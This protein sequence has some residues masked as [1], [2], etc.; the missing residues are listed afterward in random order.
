M[1]GETCVNVA[2]NRTCSAP[3]SRVS[4]W[5]SEVVDCGASKPARRVRVGGGELG[6]VHVRPEHDVDDP[7]DGTAAVER[8]GRD[9][10]D[11]HPLDQVDGD[12]VHIR[13]G[14]TRARQV[15]GQRGHNLRQAPP[16][17]QDDGRVDAEAPEVEV[18]APR[19]EARDARVLLGRERRRVAVQDLRL[20]ELVQVDDPAACDLVPGEDREVERVVLRA[21]QVHVARRRAGNGRRP[22]VADR[23]RQGGAPLDDK[24]LEPGR[25]T[26]LVHPLGPKDQDTV[27]LYADAGDDERLES[28]AGR[29][30]LV[31]ARRHP[32]NCELSRW[33]G[34]CREAR[35]PH[36]H[37]DSRSRLSRRGQEPSGDRPLPARDCRHHKT[38]LSA[39]LGGKARAREDPVQRLLGLESSRE[40]R[41]ARAVEVVEGEEHLHVPLAGE[42]EQ[43]RVGRLSRDVE[44]DRVGQERRREQ[45]PYPDQRKEL[46]QRGWVGVGLLSARQRM[47][48]SPRSAG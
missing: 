11:L 31:G 1:G 43:C 28:P 41:R 46:D 29:G 19:G 30:E 25:V 34:R 22:L 14:R 24:G 13:L 38:V 23:P 48:A 17:D 6:G 44:V 36:H 33:I 40:G 8:G 16:V 18:A 42:C 4:P 5:R 2:L 32:A 21:G 39:S 37:A 9:R 15:G 47:T 35:V 45:A 27:G 12:H 3:P 10:K 26:R 7:A 20:Q